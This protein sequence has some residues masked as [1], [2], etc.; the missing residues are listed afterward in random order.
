VCIGGDTYCSNHPYANYAMNNI[1]KKYHIPTV[2]W[3]CS[4][5][6]GILTND[7]MKK[8]IQKYRYIVARESLTHEILQKCI[9]SD[10]ILYQACDPAFHLEIK[11]TELP[12]VF[13]SGDVIGINLSPYF[14]SQTNCEK[15]W[16]NVQ[17]LIDYIISETDYNI[18]FIPHVFSFKNANEDML[19]LNNLYNQY[20]KESRIAFLNKD[21]S[22]TEIKYVISKCRFFIG[23]RTHSMI[24]A[25]STGVPALALSYSIKSKGIAKDIFGTIKGYVLS[26]EEMG[27]H[28]CLKNTFVQNI[29]HKEEFI[30][31]VYELIMPVYKQSIIKVADDIFLN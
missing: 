25:Y 2:L 28:N 11:E 17:T 20:K 26:K 6:D 29:L 18:C 13:L 30:R 22:C 5:D 7:T 4:V 14:V 9:T 10:Q 1:A 8:D 27:Q 31:S 21:L 16:Q 3:G 15:I 24:A 12:D 23:A 19:V